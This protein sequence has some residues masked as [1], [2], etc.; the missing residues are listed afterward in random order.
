LEET[1]VEDIWSAC[2]TQ[3]EQQTGGSRYYLGLH[4]A[5]Y[6]FAR[7]YRCLV[8]RK[9]PISA[10]L[11]KHSHL[12]AQLAAARAQQTLAQKG[13]LLTERAWAYATLQALKK[14]F[15]QHQLQADCNTFLNNPTFRE[16]AILGWQRPGVKVYDY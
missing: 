8:A 14:P 15:N 6:F 1:L 11:L 5:D 10:S 9:Q 4:A 12:V 16:P 7:T 3:L 2:L 13:S